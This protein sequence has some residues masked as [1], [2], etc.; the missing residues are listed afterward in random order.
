MKNLR[1]TGERL[2]T[3]AGALDAL[4]GLTFTRA[5]IITGGRSMF[6]NGTI[7]RAEELLSPRGAVEIYHGIPANPTCADVEAGLAVMRRFAP[8]LVIA[9]GGGSSIDAAKAMLL[10][11]EWPTL[12]F[13]NVFQSTLPQKRSKTT[14]VAVPSTS[15]TAS[16]VTHVTVITFPEQQNKLA[17]KT[18]ALR[19]DIALSLIHILSSGGA[20]LLM[21]GSFDDL[22]GSV[23]AYIHYAAIAI[24]TAPQPQKRGSILK[25]VGPHFV[26]NPECA[27]PPAC[28]AVG[29][30]AAAQPLQCFNRSC[31][32]KS[33]MRR[34]NHVFP[35]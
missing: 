7:R 16:E 15:G 30:I 17:I 23:T 14:F 25:R 5:L 8:D 24:S 11:Y 21:E 10:F 19:P 35:T 31:A 12:N 4:G 2:I 34:D 27:L 28:Q 32:V 33:S 3:G 26:D 29:Q 1:L 22:A 18:E 6:R 20:V 13:D 9:I